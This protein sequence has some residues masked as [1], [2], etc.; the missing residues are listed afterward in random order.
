MNLV[1]QEYK[2]TCKLKCQDQVFK[3]PVTGIFILKES[4]LALLSS[5]I[6]ILVIQANQ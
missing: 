2:Q 5:Q 6:Q 3:I 4:A 1:K